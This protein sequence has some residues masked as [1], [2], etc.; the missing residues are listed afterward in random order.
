MID[1]RRAFDLRSDFQRSHSHEQCAVIVADYLKD[2][3]ASEAAWKSALQ[4]LRLRHRL[5]YWRWNPLS[6]LREVEAAM[7]FCFPKR[8]GDEEREDQQ[9]E[10]RN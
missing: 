6:N 4:V 7:G 10:I 5:K 9:I 1:L 2:D 3:A 8:K